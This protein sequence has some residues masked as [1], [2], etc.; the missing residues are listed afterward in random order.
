MDLD[1]RQL[2]AFVTTSEELH[3][4]RAASRLFLTQQA[5][6]HR[7][8][9][10]E[11]TLGGPLFVRGHHVVELTDLGRRLLPLSRQALAVADEIVAAAQ[12]GRQPLRLDTFRP[13][14][15][16]ALLRRLITDLGDLPLELSTRHSLG[17]ALS[18]LQRA[19]IDVAFGRVHGLP[20]PWPDDL[21][22]R[23]LRLE[24]LHALMSERH[25]LATR[26][27]LR[28]ADLRPQGIWTPA[29]AGATEL[30]GYLRALGDHFRIPLA[31]GPA[32]A[33]LDQVVAQIHA[34]PDRVWLIDADVQTAHIPATAL[35]P[36]VDP[37]PLYPWSLVWR[38][39]NRHP[40]LPRL[41]RTAAATARREGWLR[42]EPARH[43][44]PAEDRAAA[45]GAAPI[46][47]DGAG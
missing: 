3:F 21:A 26:P 34:H 47:R 46:D 2:Q 36:L 4:G 39:D 17:T 12:L 38:H 20:H 43:W 31:I 25:P 7:I 8:R 33:T 10:L 27:T 18:A 42:Y 37:T 5:L 24:P 41:L 16:S 29:L 11:A 44:L 35:I 32:V 19:E 28:P 14:A 13:I 6:S 22:H 30:D 40:L 9:R 45:T 1:L 15:A 23:L